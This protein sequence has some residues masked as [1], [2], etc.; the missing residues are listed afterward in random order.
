MPQSWVAIGIVAILL[1][2]AIAVFNSLV[3]KRNRVRNAWADIDVQLKRRYDLVPNLVETVKGYKGYEASVLENVTK[4]RTNAMNQSGAAG[5]AEA[6]NTLSGALKSLFAVAENYPELRASENL[7]KLQEEL[8][9]L[10]SDIQSARRYYNAAVRE[11]N[12]AVQVFPA[13]LVAGI[14]GFKQSEFFGADE[15]EK[16][17]VKVSF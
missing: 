5:K 11:L 10:E 8:S 3:G 1:V 15:N 6:E 4:A 12:N 16:V 13:S 9:S 17:A 7:R 2:W 14:L